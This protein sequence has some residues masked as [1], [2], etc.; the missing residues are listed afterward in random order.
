MN[1]VYLGLGSNVG[2]K[3]ENIRKVIKEFLLDI[4]FADVEYSSLYESVPYGEIEQK[5]FINGVISF[6]TDLSVDD[7]FLY[8]KELEKKIGRVKREV[9]GPREID[10]DILL[11]E[12]SVVENDKLSIPHKDLL[13]RDFVL[14]PLIELNENLIHPIEKKKLKSFLS[15]LND[16]YII[17]QINFSI[18]EPKVVEQ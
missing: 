6:S 14:I 12:K 15:E 8:T 4:R 17:G 16:K 18:S 5:N 11:Y 3:I 1:K 10:I 9:W 2:D 7:L 13:N